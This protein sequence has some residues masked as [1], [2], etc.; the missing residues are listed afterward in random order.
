MRSTGHTYHLLSLLVYL[1]KIHNCNIII[2][3]VFPELR[4]KALHCNGA[5]TFVIIL[6]GIQMSNEFQRGIPLKDDPEISMLE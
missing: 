3:R 6:I 5:E 4:Q 1:Y 2:Y